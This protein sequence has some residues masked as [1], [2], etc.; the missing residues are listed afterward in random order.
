MW[1]ASWKNSGAR[2]RL[3]SLVTSC[4][5]SFQRRTLKLLL[6]PS[7]AAAAAAALLRRL[8]LLPGTMP[9]PPASQR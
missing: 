5:S 7:A 2:T 8:P 9:W 3:T 6:S 4:T 1:R